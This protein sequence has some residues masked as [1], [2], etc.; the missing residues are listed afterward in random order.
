MATALTS[1]ITEIDISRLKRELESLGNVR[2]ISITPPKGAIPATVILTQSDKISN[3]SPS[4]QAQAQSRIDNHVDYL[5]KA[6]QLLGRTKLVA[7]TIEPGNIE[8]VN[9]GV[10]WKISSDKSLLPGGTGRNIGSPSSPVNVI[11]ANNIVGSTG[12]LGGGTSSIYGETPLGAIDGIN[13]T[14]LT[15]NTFIYGTTRVFLNGIRLLPGAGNA[16]EE[17]TDNSIVL[18][19]APQPGDELMIDYDPTA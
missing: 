2:V 9:N 5:D 3:L 16:Y 10:A 4:Q 8:F 19:A 6:A 18:S 14:F 11:Y 15:T 12:S 13:A 7:G 1:T 17:A